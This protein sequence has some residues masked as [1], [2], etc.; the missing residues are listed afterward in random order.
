MWSA[1]VN[2]SITG[3]TDRRGGGTADSVSCYLMTMPLVV[4]S[5]NR[6]SVAATPSALH[7]LL[8]F[9]TPVGATH[10]SRASVRC[11]ASGPVRLRRSGTPAALRWA[12]DELRRCATRTLCG[13]ISAQGMRRQRLA[14]LRTQATQFTAINAISALQVD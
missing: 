9:R 4:W 11:T 14:T 13:A 8:C 3:E 1:D 2:R 5:S 12:D 7:K 10:L 6:P